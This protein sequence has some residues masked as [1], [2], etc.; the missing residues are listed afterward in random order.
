MSHDEDTRE[1]PE[2]LDRGVLHE[3]LD[4]DRLMEELN[5]LRLEGRYFCFDPREAKRRT[6][7]LRFGELVKQPVTIEIHPNYGQPSV[8]AYKVL[9][10]I[11]LKMTEEGYPYPESVSFSQRE[12]ARLAGR[13]WSG[14][15][16]QQIHEAIM[17]LRTTLVHCSF[18]HKETKDWVTANF[19]VLSG[20]LFA[21]RGK[22]INAC[23]VEVDK[24]IVQ[25]LNKR[26]IAFFNWY[27]LNRLDTIGMVLYKRVFFHL[28]NLN[29]PQKSKES[30]SFE[31]DYAAIC[32]EWLGGLKPER[33][34]SRILQNQLGRHLEALK[35]TL[36]IRKYEVAKK[37]GGEG[38]KIVFYPGK[39]FFDDY[40]EY[41]IKSQQPQLRFGQSVALRN[42][43]QPLEL[44]AYFHKLLGR[45]HTTFQE[46]ETAYASKLLERYSY[47]EVRDLID[48][49]IAA[50]RETN[51]SMQFLGAVKQYLAR[52]RSDRARQAARKER[53]AVIDA[54]PH[55]DDSG[56]LILKNGR[57]GFTAH[58]CPHEV[59]KIAELEDRLGL[60]R[61]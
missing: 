27:R 23:T 56:H 9:Q 48:Y 30:L 22:S 18:Y 32:D 7:S 4:H 19:H 2:P 21:G 8:L 61:V 46:K 42:I 55:C 45:E 36:L 11:F 49:A 39:G 53:Q 44:V 10:A 3:L 35:R 12:L 31:K 29:H 20:A 58:A 41:Y 33:Y 60:Y 5:I 15:T 14:R 59:E 43:Q 47:S 51:F 26:H 25:S 34:K 13:V 28:S 37:A 52:W 54:C 38:F 40:H 6:G 16:S 1:K 57:G 24:R 50:A 17:Q